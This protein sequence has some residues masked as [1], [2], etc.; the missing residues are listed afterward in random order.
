MCPPYSHSNYDDMVKD[1][2]TGYADA[3]NESLDGAT[4]NV[5]RCVVKPHQDDT[6]ANDDD[7]DTVVEEEVVENVDGVVDCDVSL[8]GAW[9]RRGYASLNGFVCH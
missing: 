8:D 3:L 5:K 4:R 9:Q 7:G 6:S 1:V 2:S